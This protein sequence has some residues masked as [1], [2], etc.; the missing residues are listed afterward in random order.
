MDGSGRA[1]RLELAGPRPLGKSRRGFRL[2]RKPLLTGKQLIRNYRD[3]LERAA[4]QIKDK[5]LEFLDT[6]APTGHKIEDSLGMQILL[7]LLSIPSTTL[8]TVFWKSGMK[9]LD[10]FA[11]SA[12]LDA[13]KDT[14]QAIV[15]ASFQ[16]GRVFVERETAKEV[17][18][19]YIYDNLIGA[20]TD[21]LDTLTVA[22]FDGS[23]EQLRNLD[24]IMGDGA[25]VSG[26]RNGQTLP[27]GTV[28]DNHTAAFL[29]QQAAQRAFYAAAIPSVWKMRKPYE[30]Y[31][32][33]LDFDADCDR[34][35][36]SGKFFH[37]GEDF[38]Q[39]WI[40]LDGHNYI[41]AGTYDRRN[42]GPNCSPEY[43][44]WCNNPDANW[45]PLFTLPGLKE[46]RDKNKKFGDVTVEDLVAGYVQPPLEQEE[47]EE[48][49]LTCGNSSVATWLHNDKKNLF[50]DK[51]RGMVID[52][53]NRAEF[54][55][56]W[57]NDIRAPGAIRIPVCSVKEAYWLAIL[58]LGK[59]IPEEDLPAFPCLRDPAK[60][61]E[62]I[63]EDDDDGPLIG[64]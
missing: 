34:D 42:K 16:I 30:M 10:F 15:M 47:E 1:S 28:P 12:K 35:I 41:L 26:S 45:Q 24:A 14:S 52:P 4:I 40:C 50:M 63:E 32:V 59:G 31:P 51:D 39:G 56:M 46:I 2:A 64:S 53:A 54:D 18:F 21:Q 33:I 62:I 19:N 38:N 8:G 6:F 20:W 55:D 57:D 29:E 22:L 5:K 48:E 61:Y 3:S 9:N 43:Y 11:N 17:S 58:G 27:A 13:Y 44:H 7:I 37:G 49:E 25:M 60:M 23:D 36:G